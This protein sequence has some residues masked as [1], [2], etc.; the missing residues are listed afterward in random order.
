[1]KRILYPTALLVAALAAC[2]PVSPGLTAEDR[3]VIAASS[4]DWVDT[5]N[6]NDWNA[7]AALFAPDAT[8]M[9]PNSPE[10]RGREAIAAWESEYETGFRIALQIEEIEGRGDLAYIRGRSCVFIP[11]GDEIY[12]VDVGKYLEVR[13]KQPD[14]AW[15]ITKDIFNSDAAIGSDL[16]EACPFGTLE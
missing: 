13:E 9:P 15:L 5:Y 3:A 7:L 10:V 8:M 2:Q 6:Q 16:L 14:G 11:L 4:Q 12:G 1:M